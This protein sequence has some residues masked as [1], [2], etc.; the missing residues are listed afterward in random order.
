M[1]RVMG[2]PFDITF[3][4]PSTPTVAPNAVGIFVEI[5]SYIRE[6]IEAFDPHPH[7]VA[8]E[9]L[10]EECLDVGLGLETFISH[11]NTARR[12]RNVLPSSDRIVREK[13][14]SWLRHRTLPKDRA[15]R[16]AIERI[17]AAELTRSA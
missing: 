15:K 8:M 3:T 12:L 14:R 7:I 4:V 1:H 13:I 2:R 5:V 17:R 11:P 9:R 16:E 6:V 10:Y